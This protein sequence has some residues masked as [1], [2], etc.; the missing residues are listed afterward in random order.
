ML[1]LNVRFAATDVLN[2]LV[3]LN[4]VP[5]V[6]LRLTEINKT[7]N[8]MKV[9]MIVLLLVT[10]FNAL[11]SAN[12]VKMVVEFVQIVLVIENFSTLQIQPVLVLKTL[13]V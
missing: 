11:L 1:I 8:V 6:K 10:V 13:L 9:I 7:V 4:S 12:L 2:V 5:S 3:Q